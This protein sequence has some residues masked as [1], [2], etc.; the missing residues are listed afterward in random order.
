[1]S[2]SATPALDTWGFY[3]SNDPVT[4]LP[5][6]PVEHQN[7]F[8]FNL[9]GPSVPFGSLGRKLFYF[10]N[11][12]KFSQSSTHPTIE[13]F[14]SVAEQQGN[15]QGIQ[16]IYDPNTETACTSFYGF[17]CRYRF[18]YTHGATPGTV[19][20]PTA[21]VLNGQPVDVIPASE[22]NAIAQ[23]IQ[24]FMPTVIN[25]LLIN[26]NPTNNFV[27]PDLKGLHNYS[28]THRVDYNVTAADTLTFLYAHGEQVSNK[29]VGFSPGSTSNTAP[30]PYNFGQAYSPKTDVDIIEETHVFSPHIVNQ[31]KF[32]FA[33]YISSQLNLEDD[34]RYSATSL[35]IT[36]APA[37]QAADSFPKVSFSGIDAPW[38]FAGYA[39]NIGAANSFEVLDNV[40][41]ELGKHS[42][43]VGGMI[44]WLQYTFN[45]DT[46]GT[47]PVS[48]SNAVTETAGIGPT[49]ALIS[50]TG[51]AYASF[52]LGA[53]DNVT[54]TQ[55]NIQATYARFRPMSPYVQDTWKVSDKLTLD[56]GLRYDFFPTYQ[57]KNNVMSFFD[58]TL[59][60]PVTGTKG[61][62]NF[63]GTGS[64]TCNC[65]TQ[66]NNY[67]KNIGP[68]IGLAYAIDSKTVI[69][70]SY[71]VMYSQGNGVGGSTASRQGTGTIGFSAAPS[72]ASN[73][74]TY[75]TTAPL[76]GG[77]PTY[78]PALGIASGPAY[79]TGYTTTAGYTGSPT[80]LTYGDPYL[81]GRAPQFINYTFGFQR[82]WTANLTTSVTYVGSQ[83]HF[84]F[85]TGTNARGYYAD[86]LDPQYLS[87]GSCLT[88]KVSSLATTT[89]NGQNCAAAVQQAGCFHSCV[90][91]HR[92]AVAAGAQT[93]PAIRCDGQLWRRRKRA[94]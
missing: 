14:P 77:V 54:L 53:P 75:Q 40:Q 51:V 49:G 16:P 20:S 48:I 63:A 13:T 62:L 93:I 31:A 11:Y 70:S 65:R 91:Q 19:A 18:G 45:P 5:K 33:R 74:S 27:S 39:A 38:T 34:P 60:N 79:G 42:L 55:N 82:Q 36:G 26:T 25:P 37:G 30:Q 58:P 81:G 64:G 10:G 22:I 1:M 8:G 92:P 76:S 72:F 89:V 46:G 35:G 12:T 44:S 61:A 9:S 41:W 86:Q 3:K 71:G 32:G 87:L 57:E 52:L 67:F 94:L 23:N 28:T 78:A 21:Q 4:G 6:K 85:A 80:T 73:T 90:V 50:S 66:V 43:T 59:T 2:F 83:G 68:R 24:G 29:P 15:F 84:L 17:T 56:L 47:S 88:T 7:E 69:R